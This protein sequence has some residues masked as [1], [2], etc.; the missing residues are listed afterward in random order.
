[1]NDYLPQ[2]IHAALRRARFLAKPIAGQQP[3]LMYQHKRYPRM[4]QIPLAHRK[5]SGV[6][7]AEALARRA[8]SHTFDNTR[9]PSAETFGEMLDLA[10]RARADGTR[11]YPSG[12]ALY[13][14]ETYL[15]VRCAEGLKSGAYHYRPDVHALEY[16]WPLLHAAGEREA[17]RETSVVE[18]APVLIV[19]TSVWRRN[20]PKYHEFGFE[21]ALIEA[22]HIGQNIVLASA[23]LG[24]AACPLGGFA[25]AALSTQFDL[26]PQVEQPVY[27]IAVGTHHAKHRNH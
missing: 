23:A 11:P 12:G 26:D 25:D 4:R 13:P 3:V 8:S 5:S 1:M 24:L 6:D 20:T 18:S 16:L 14:I 10:A 21:L 2:R 17:T 27:A 15:V 9:A 19:L 7:L 22:G